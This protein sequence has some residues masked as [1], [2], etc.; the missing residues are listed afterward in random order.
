MEPYLKTDWSF[1]K[2]HDN[3]T[4]EKKCKKFE[5]KGG[6]FKYKIVNTCS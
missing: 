1:C 5:G 3:F 2:V 6:E 4:K